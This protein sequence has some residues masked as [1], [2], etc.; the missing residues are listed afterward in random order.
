MPFLLWIN[1]LKSSNIP[2]GLAAIA[3]KWAFAALVA[4]AVTACGGGNDTNTSS[5][6]VGAT[7]PVNNTP[8]QYDTLQTR[9]NNPNIDYTWLTYIPSS[10]SRSHTNYIVVEGSSGLQS[11]DYLQVV[12]DAKTAAKTSGPQVSSQGF[13]YLRP[14]FPAPAIGATTNN[15]TD[16]A[17]YPQGLYR[18]SLMTSN[19][20]KYRPDLRLNKMIGRIQK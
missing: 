2:A 17:R 4:V 3:P 18:G 6:A 15:V 9:V 13:I 14:V 16:Y 12:E 1:M 7:N 11:D 20:F 5:V 8:L 19:E 10:I